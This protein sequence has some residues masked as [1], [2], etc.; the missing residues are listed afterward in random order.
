MEIVGLF[1][2]NRKL[3]KNYRRKN[4]ENYQKITGQPQFN[5]SIEHIKSQNKQ[6][7]IENI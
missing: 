3:Q 2:V 6:A 4:Y 5:A 7:I 1:W